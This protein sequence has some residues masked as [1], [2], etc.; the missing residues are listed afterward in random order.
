MSAWWWLYWRLYETRVP[1]AE[2]YSAMGGE[3]PRARRWLHL[4]ELTGL[5]V[6]RKGHVELTEPGA[7][8][9]HLGQTQFALNYVDTLVDP[10]AAGALA[11]PDRPLN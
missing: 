11:S 3:A 8:W 9:V 5:A 6:R 2:V 10:S 7:Y 1:L 4:L